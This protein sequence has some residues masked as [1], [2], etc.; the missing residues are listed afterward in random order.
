M[1]IAVPEFLTKLVTTMRQKSQ[2]CATV[3]ERAQDETIRR[4]ISFC[5]LMESRRAKMLRRTLFR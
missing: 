3:Q 4:T 1:T 5:T 2:Q